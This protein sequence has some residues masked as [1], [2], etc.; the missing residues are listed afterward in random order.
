MDNKKVTAGRDR[1]GSLAPKFAELNDDVLFGQ[2][3][4]REEEL[5]ARDRSLVTIVSLIAGGNFEQLKSHLQRGKDNGL[6]KQEIVEI[7]TH[8]AFY[9]GWPKA[10][11][12][13]NIVK[14]V[15]N[16]TD[17]TKHTIL[18]KSTVFPLGEPVNPQ[19]F[20][21]EA[22]LQ[23]IS[24]ENALNTAVANVTFAPGTASDSWFVHLALTSGESEW[25]EH[26]ADEEYNSVQTKQLSA[27]LNNSQEKQ[28]LNKQRNRV[29][30]SLITVDSLRL[31]EYNSL[32]E[33]GIRA[34]MLLEPGVLT[35]YA[36]AEKEQPHK[37]TILEIYADEKAYQSHIQTPHFLKYKQ[38]TLDMVQELELKD[39]APLI[40]GFMIKE[41]VSR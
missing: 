26:V 9:S 31:K 11:S 22:W 3:W 12:A 19:W 38:G 4:S 13:F 41:D 17:A 28:D 25:Y 8:Q 21:G 33:E 29:S 39:V 34:A 10:W 35:L 23:M 2:V 36:V 40:P 1:L 20:T 37:I 7:I 16:E 32:L 18:E 24:T 27:A 6:S 5:P 14:E 30:L 15:Y